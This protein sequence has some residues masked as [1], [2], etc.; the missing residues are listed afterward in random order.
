MPIPHDYHIFI[1]KSFDG[2]RMVFHEKIINPKDYPT[3]EK[4]LEAIR[5]R[6]EFHE[7]VKEVDRIIKESKTD[8]EYKRRIEELGFSECD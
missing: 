6:E 3:F 8:E 2:E 7:R 4:Y 5:I 1:D